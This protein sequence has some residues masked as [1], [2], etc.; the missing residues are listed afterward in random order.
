MHG[1]RGAALR[2]AR[3]AAL[4]G[5]A[6]AV[7]AG[8]SGGDGDAGGRNGAAAEQTARPPG[9]H[10]WTSRPC[11]LLAGAA[12]AEGFTLGSTTDSAPSDARED[13]GE[14]GAR[15]LYRQTG[16]LADLKA[17]DGTFWKLSTTA[18]V[19]EDTEPARHAYRVKEDLDRAHG[20]GPEK[21]HDAAYAIPADDQGRPGR[22][23][24]LWN[25]DLVL[26][27]SAYA[28]HGSTE[29][30]VRKELERIVGDAARRTEDGLRD[31]DASSSAP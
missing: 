3:S 17:P 5:L 10:S 20:R 23:L 14:N 26:T 21:V 15:P 9:T 25:G 7:S 12:P 6:V 27:V 29:H 24:L 2:R 22:T 8:C 28:P 11:A 4:I 19:Y 31:D 13:I 18:S 1:S 30:D 16:C